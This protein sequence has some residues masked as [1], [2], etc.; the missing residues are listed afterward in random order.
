MDTM[1][2]F[3]GVKKLVLESDH[4][5]PLSAQVENGG[6]IPPLPHISS[7]RIALLMQHR[8]NFKVYVFI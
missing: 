1:G 6:A 2:S 8:E 7:W 4:S 5:P 3:P